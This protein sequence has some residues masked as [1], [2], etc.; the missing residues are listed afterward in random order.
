LAEDIFPQNKTCLQVRP[1]CSILFDVPKGQLLENEHIHQP[2]YP[3]I[4]RIAQQ[5]TGPIFVNRTQDYVPTK[6]FEARAHRLFALMSGFIVLDH[7]AI[8]YPLKCYLFHSDNP[9]EAFIPLCKSDF[10]TK[11]EKRLHR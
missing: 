3:T 8:R 4:V 5:P 1:C 9:N 10:N 2:N 11:A 7:T 6:K